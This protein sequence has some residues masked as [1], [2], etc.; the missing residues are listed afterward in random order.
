MA[1]PTLLITSAINPAKEMRF[2]RM[3]DPSLRYILS[4]AAFY[5]WIAIG[6][7]NIV[8]V[9]ASDEKII[10]NDELNL[11][12]SL[13]INL[14]QLS[15]KQ[16]EVLVREK[17]KGYGEG[18]IIEFALE[19]SELIKKTNNFFKCTSKIY[20]R[21]FDHINSM[22][23]HN[24]MQNIFWKYLND[25][26]IM[27]PWADLRFFY[28]TRSFCKD[29]VIPAYLNSNDKDIACEFNCYNSLNENLQQSRSLRPLL[30]G[31]AG[32]TGKQYFDLSLGALDN[33]YPCWV[34]L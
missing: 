32:G 27:K 13:N 11:I 12:K 30:S 21:N 17:G 23:M 10:N 3:Q 20:C 26:E 5:F 2:L 7:R 8:F 6:I 14:E 25:V 18:K 33:N 4:K 1:E 24:K 15:F 22:I 31:F 34:G 9:D 16:N 29:I 28:S 19:N